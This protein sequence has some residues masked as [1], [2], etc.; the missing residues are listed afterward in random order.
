MTKYHILL[1]S[2]FLPVRMAAQTNEDIETDGI[3]AG[4]FDSNS[5]S[6]LNYSEFKLPPLSIL[7]ENAQSNPSVERLAT[8]EAIQRELVKK[9]IL[10]P[11]K[12]VTGHANYTYGIMD[13]YGSNSTVTTPIYYQYMGS[14]Q[15]FWNFGAS[16]N[17]PLDDAFDYFGRIRR[18]KLTANKARQEKEMAYNE[19][20]QQIATLYVR[21]TNNIVALKTAGEN[22][23]AYKGAGQLTNE[24][25]KMGEVSV[26]ALAET[27]RWENEAIATYQELQ[28]RITTDILMLEILT[29]T[30]IITNIIVD[31]KL[32]KK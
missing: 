4:Y 26:R 32:D 8:E 3:I 13:N 17:I 10:S 28:S 19:L 23:A 21:I 27:K 30:P 24:E 16:V 12:Y 31:S 29:H 22:A 6:K 11:L 15:T 2:L 20:K 25:F 9:E 1:L 5:Q 14:K 7:F 18:Q